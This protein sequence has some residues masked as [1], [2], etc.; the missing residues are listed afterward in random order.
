MLA[1]LAQARRDISRISNQESG[2]RDKDEGEILHFEN[3]CGPCRYMHWNVLARKGLNKERPASFLK[4]EKRQV[5][6][7]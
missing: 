5:Y 3:R 4:V 6:N 7:T 2:S 1:G